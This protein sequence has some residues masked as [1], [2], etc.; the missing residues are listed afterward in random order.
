M[1]AKLQREGS[2]SIRGGRKQGGDKRGQRK[3]ESRWRSRSKKGTNA[4]GGRVAAGS[5]WPIR[6]QAIS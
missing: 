3:N 1:R 2:W 5:K 6:E 4:T